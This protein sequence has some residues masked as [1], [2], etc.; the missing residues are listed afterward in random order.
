M[1]AAVNLTLTN[2]ELELIQLFAFRAEV[3]GNAEMTPQ[4]ISESIA[5][6]DGQI[7]AFVVRELDKADAIAANLRE[8]EIRAATCKADAKHAAARAKFWESN[9]EHLEAVTI[10]ALQLRDKPRIETARTTLRIQRNPAAVDVFDLDKV[11]KPYVKFTVEMTGALYERLLDHLGWSVDR[12]QAAGEL[13]RELMAAKTSDPTPMKAQIASEIKN[14]IEVP[15]A[16]M[17]EGVHRLVVE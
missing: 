5:A 8:F 15:G 12:G 1:S 2:I 16:R 17:R 6:V 4:E 11:P 10:K 7:E 13:F 9:A 14:K 3:A